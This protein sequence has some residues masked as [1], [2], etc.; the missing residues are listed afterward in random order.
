MNTFDLFQLSAAE[1]AALRTRIKEWDGLVRV[2]I[3]PLFEK[4]RWGDDYLHDPAGSAWVDIEKGLS[5]ILSLPEDKVP[6]VI[7][8]EE[9][10][11][12]EKLSKWVSNNRY[13]TSRN[14]PYIIRTEL[15]YP[16]LYGVL[17][18]K[19]GW[20][21]I[22]DNFKH[23]GISHILMGGM[24]FEAATWK[25]DW[26]DKGPWVAGCVGIALSYLSKD[27]AGSFSVELSRIIDD[28]D[29]RSLYNK[30]KHQEAVKNYHILQPD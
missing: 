17:D 4:M 26:T 6:P 18:R 25:S 13:G 15:K 3:H 22:S 10:P 5:R 28:P 19:S 29:S 2:F 24:Q 21:M 12:V 16:A 23:M 8:F 20:K 27:K 9:H 14:N 30:N 11:Y 7:I 1:Q